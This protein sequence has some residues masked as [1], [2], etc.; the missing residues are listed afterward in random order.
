VS[1]KIKAFETCLR[2]PDFH[3]LRPDEFM[4]NPNHGSP[5]ESSMVHDILER[6]PF[7]PASPSYP[8]AL[9]E[10]AR[11]ATAR[12]GRAEMKMSDGAFWRMELHQAI[13]QSTERRIDI[14]RRLDIEAELRHETAEVAGE[15]HRRNVFFQRVFEIATKR[16]LR[17]RRV[18]QLELALLDFINSKGSK[19]HV[20]ELQE[21]QMLI[22]HGFA[23]HAKYL[24][25]RL[26]NLYLPTATHGLVK[27]K[28]H[29]Q[30]LEAVVGRVLADLRQIVTQHHHAWRVDNQ[31]AALP[32]GTIVH[33]RHHPGM[34]LE[35]VTAQ[36][37][38]QQMRQ[39]MAKS[40][41]WHDGIHLVE[42]ANHGLAHSHLGGRMPEAATAVLNEPKLQEHAR[43]DL[44][45]HLTHLLLTLPN[46]GFIATTTHVLGQTP[47]KITGDIGW[48]ARKA[49][50]HRHQEWRLGNLYQAT[51]NGGM[52]PLAHHGKAAEH[53][54][55]E[56]ALPKKNAATKHT[57]DWHANHMFAATAN[58]G[59][60]PLKGR[61]RSEEGVMAK[62]ADKPKHAATA[63]FNDWHASHQ[64]GRTPNAGLAPLKGHGHP[65]EGVMAEIAEKPK[66][67]AIAGF[68][69]WHASHQFGRTSNAGYAPLKGHGHSIEGMAAQVTDKPKHEITA[70]FKNWHATHQ[71]QHT[72]NHGYAP[73]KDS[74]RILEQVSGDFTK[75][76]KDLI[77]QRFL[78]RR[79]GNLY[80]PTENGNWRKLD[81]VGKIIEHTAA[82]VAPADEGTPEGSVLL[83]TKN[84]HVLAA[85]KHQV[86]DKQR[87]ENKR[88]MREFQRSLA[89]HSQ[90]LSHLRGHVIWTASTDRVVNPGTPPMESTGKAKKV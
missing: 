44:E 1:I 11:L 9:K 10:N 38:T 6:F 78:A 51:P 37:Y 68:R 46:G 71:Y 41:L 79:L 76:S 73:L 4:I 14:R 88:D 85:V 13:R 61:G 59:F 5:R 33:V 29:G 45:W 3:V 66:Q 40:H 80:V 24:A 36:V 84:G 39:Q 89:A 34:P 48:T 42:T 77:T 35:Q 50:A 12:R 22:R 72:A 25:W 20:R 55:A 7:Q 57:D 15:E 32:S 8:Q 63:G 27:A 74:G 2:L 28:N 17:H 54:S 16:H 86:R 83:P 53:V 64:F 67:E 23:R 43:K 70:G 90:T 19:H 65:I 69:S 87:A 62:I 60:A 81:H 21:T 58:A 18:K 56:A 30:L 75:A 52:V 31:Y 49:V 26:D 47:E 82:E